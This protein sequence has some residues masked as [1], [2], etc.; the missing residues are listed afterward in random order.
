MPY[1]QRL[2]LTV[3]ASTLM[4]VAPVGAT[5]LP[6]EVENR[7]P[8][9]KAAFSRIRR[10]MTD[11]ELLV[12]MAPFREVYTGH[13]QW[14]AWTDGTLV[15]YVTLS[16]DFSGKTPDRVEYA[17]LYQKVGRDLRPLANG[18]LFIVPNKR[19]SIVDRLRMKE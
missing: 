11:E 12:L 19:I 2:G 13:H 3:L 18:A 8:S 1:S 15:I 7:N 17:S 14:P 10:G 5:P 4:F 6:R 16:M 9:L